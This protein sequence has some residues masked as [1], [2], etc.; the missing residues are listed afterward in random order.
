MC[1]WV[2]VRVYV[3]AHVCTWKS[4]DNLGFGSSGTDH[5]FCSLSRL[6][7][8][9]QGLGT[10][11]TPPCSVCRASPLW[12]NCLPAMASISVHFLSACGLGPPGITWLFLYPFLDGLKLSFILTYIQ[13]WN[14]S[15]RGHTT[16]LCLASVDVL[17]VLVLRG[18]FRK[19]GSSVVPEPVVRHDVIDEGVVQSCSPYSSGEADTRG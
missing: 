5:L 3:H 12:T 16:H 19:G 17:T 1:G 7:I 9:S 6:F 2:G 13:E 10:C 11:P 4:E 18:T 14:F 15:F 8:P